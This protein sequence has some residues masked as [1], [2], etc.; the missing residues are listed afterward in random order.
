MQHLQ[1]YEDAACKIPFGTFPFMH[2]EISQIFGYGMDT[3]SVGGKNYKGF[4]DINGNG[5]SSVF[6]ISNIVQPP[7][8]AFPFTSISNRFHT[9]KMFYTRE[10]M[11]FPVTETNVQNEYCRLGTMHYKDITAEGQQAQISGEVYFAMWLIEFTFADTKFYGIGGWTDYYQPTQMVPFFCAEESFWTEI[12]MPN[13]DYGE[14]P[15]TTGGQGTGRVPHTNIPD[16]TTPSRI[17]P[18]GG[19][20]L[21]VY[22]VTA[23]GYADVQGYLWGDASTLAKSLWQKFQN[24]THSPV[25][26]IVGCYSLPADF[27]PVSSTSSG[28]QIAGL[29]LSPVSGCYD[30]SSVIGFKDKTYHFPAIQPPFD[31]WLDYDGLKCILHVPFCGNIP[32]DNAFIIGKDLD[33]KYRVDQM[34]GNL[35]C[36]VTCAG[37]DIAELSGNCAYNVPVSG[38]DTGTLERLGALVTG[39]VQLYAHKLDDALGSAAEFFTAGYT[40]QLVNCDLHGNVTACEN[41]APYIEW[42]QPETAYTGD[43]PRTYGIPCEFSGTISTFTGGYGEFE[44]MEVNDA[45]TAV[46]LPGATDAEIEEIKAILKGGVFV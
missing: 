38:G 12:F 36:R 19:R 27:M 33:L 9:A 40:T 11:S 39:A 42:I 43:Y 8:S 2:C 14:K 18:L 24:K 10:G 30:V 22:R 44:V 28:V 6:S 7:D 41:R 37:R 26:C 4:G 13:Y 20:G 15:S 35:I 34:N 21:H 23:A 45:G 1:L 3:F 5:H 32:I 31:S 29:M 17:V 25:S 16:S 46:Y